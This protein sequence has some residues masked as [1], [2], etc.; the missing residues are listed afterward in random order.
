MLPWQ[1]EFHSSQSINFVQS[2]TLPDDDALHNFVTTDQLTL[3]INH[4]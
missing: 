3:E 4:F 1:L 2:F